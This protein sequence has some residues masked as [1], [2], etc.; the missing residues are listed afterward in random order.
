MLGCCDAGMLV[1]RCWDVGMLG[2][3]DAGML[4][5]WAARLLGCQESPGEAQMELQGPLPDQFGDHFA[6]K[7]IKMEL[8]GPQFCSIYY[9]R[10]PGRSHIYCKHANNFTNTIKHT[11]LFYPPHTHVCKFVFASIMC[12]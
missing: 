12:V 9:F 1:L 6:S 5:C 4:G 3:Q 8:R 10:S 2:C 7:M 11:L